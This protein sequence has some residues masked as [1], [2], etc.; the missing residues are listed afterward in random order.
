MRAD[1]L[2]VSVLRVASGPGVG[3]AGCG[4]ALS[5]PPPP[6][7]VCS[8]GRSGAVVPVLVLLFAALWSILR[9]DFKLLSPLHFLCTQCL[10]REDLLSFENVTSP[11]SYSV[12]PFV[13]FFKHLRPRKFGILYW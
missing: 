6:P 5:P 4:G 13:F 12:S 9:G 3:S 2:C 1:F 8:A 11:K 10:H 7:V